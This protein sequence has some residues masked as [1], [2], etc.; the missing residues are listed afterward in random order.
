LGGE[1]HGDS[2][3][4]CPKTQCNNPGLDPELLNA[5]M[6]SITNM[7]LFFLNHEAIKRLHS[8]ISSTLEIQRTVFLLTCGVKRNLFPTDSFPTYLLLDHATLYILQLFHTWGRKTTHVIESQ[9][10][11]V[12]S[13]FQGSDILFPYDISMKIYF[14]K[15]GKKESID[16]CKRKFSN[17]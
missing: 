11:T 16:I 7:S 2:N 5:E 13:L 10:Q 14:S 17:L 1:R 3:M 12:C 8:F 4:P 6:S 15:E 9:Q